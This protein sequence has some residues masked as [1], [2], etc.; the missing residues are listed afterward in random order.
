MSDELYQL[1]YVSTSSGE[2][3]ELELAELLQQSREA[4]ERHHITG[5]LMY[6]DRHYFQVIEGEK[7]DIDTLFDNIK[8]DKRHFQ[9]TRAF[10]AS[11]KERH[12]KNWSMAFIRY[13]KTS[14]VPIVGFSDYLEQKLGEQDAQL[15]TSSK[16]EADHIKTMIDTICSN[17]LRI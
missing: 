16:G 5:F 13:S 2:P 7:S 10:Y 11:I 8:R 1:V 3:Q 4:N 15:N 12:F 9:V 6:V 17:I 14:N